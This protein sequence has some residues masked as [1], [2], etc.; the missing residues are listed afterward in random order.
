MIRK[1]RNIVIAL[2]FIPVIGVKAQDFHLSMY[3]AAPIYLNPAMTGLFEGSWR[4][5]AQYRDQWRAVNF[6]PYNTALL[7]FD[8]SYKKWGFGVQFANY[9]AGAGNFNIFQGLLSVAYNVPLG[10]KKAHNLAFGVQGGVTNKSVQYQLLTFDNQYT[11][12]NGG[13]F[14]Q[15]M[16]SGEVFDVQSRY[17]PIVNFGMLY[18]FSK[19]ESRLNPFVG[20]S[21]FN[22]INPNESF[23]GDK[24]KYPFR[25]YG[26]AGVR[27]N[28]TELFYIVPK[29]L[30][31]NQDKFFEQTY[32][33][34]LGYYISSSDLYLLGGLVYRN[35][36][37]MVFSLG[38]KISNITAKFAY[39]VNMSRLTNTSSGKG[40]YEISLTYVFSKKKRKE[41][42]KICPRL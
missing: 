32:A 41:Y 40:A 15:T 11:T 18:Y 31:M 25:F 36:D 33:L 17:T 14:D 27:I 5:H 16:P 35:A 24:A 23:F 21:A 6:K 26:H 4:L 1:I 42:E 2:V 10:A 29:V 20:V 8:A 38:L 37:A 19:Q 12:A 13:G 30:V 39:D 22:L 3:D 34:D 28:I 9:R 7:S